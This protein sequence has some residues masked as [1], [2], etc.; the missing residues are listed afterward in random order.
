MS[1]L[2]LVLSAKRIIIDSLRVVMDY[3]NAS[4]FGSYTA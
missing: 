2:V 1:I 4:H 3:Q